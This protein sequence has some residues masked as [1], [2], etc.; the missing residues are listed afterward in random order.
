MGAAEIV[1]IGETMAVML[2]A[3]GDRLGEASDYGLTYAGA[4]SNV[5]VGLARLGHRV[6]FVSRLGDDH[7]GR[8]IRRELRGEGVDVDGVALDP[9]LPTG[10]LVR[11]AAPVGIS[12]TYYRAGSAATALAPADV[13]LDVVR[14]A[15][16]LHLTG[17]TAAISDSARAACLHAARHA[18]AAG[19]AVS[20][21]PNVRLRL[22]SPERWRAIADELAPLADVLLVGA[23]DAAAIGVDDPAAWGHEH[24]AEIVVVKDG[25]R[26]ATESSGGSTWHQRALPV[27]VLDPVGAGDAFA[28][29]WLSGWLRGLDPSRR[30]AEAAAVAAC[31]VASRGDVPGLPDPALRDRVLDGAEG[32]SR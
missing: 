26:G 31:V 19:V 16:L 4:E 27:P 24:G 1:T 13:P 25:A 29:G 10:L 20:V 21:D 17:I 18:R 8:R 12:V 6:A 22:A 28:A 11:D 9:R 30:L 23:D 7:L 3:P 2:A 5:A 32:V 14:G 15:R